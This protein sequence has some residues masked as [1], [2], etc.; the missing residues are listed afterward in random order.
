MI[1]YEIFIGAFFNFYSPILLSK[2]V[3]WAYDSLITKSIELNKNIYEPE[4]FK[5]LNSKEFE[6]KKELFHE[7]RTEFNFKNSFLKK[8]LKYQTL[9]LKI[10]SKEYHNL[11]NLSNLVKTILRDLKEGHSKGYFSE[12]ITHFFIKRITKD[13]SNFSFRYN[14]AYYVGVKDEKHLFSQEFVYK[15]SP[16]AMSFGLVRNFYYEQPE[17]YSTQGPLGFFDYF[18][19]N[20]AQPVRQNNY[21]D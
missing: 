5:T 11:I 7:M 17:D 10:S 19:P 9:K 18:F 14:K 15:Y 1:I 3:S 4:T 6:I 16:D 8:Y 13:F 12:E 2:E 20:A 21:N